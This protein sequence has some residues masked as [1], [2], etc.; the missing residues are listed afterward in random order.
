MYAARPKKKT[1]I[2]PPPKELFS[3]S[4]SEEDDAP[5]IIKPFQVTPASALQ[6]RSPIQLS[7]TI[8]SVTVNPGFYPVTNP[9]PV[10]KI[11]GGLP[12][13]RVVQI[14][15]WEREIADRKKKLK[16]HPMYQFA[17]LVAGNLHYQSLDPILEPI[18]EYPIADAYDDQN[19][20]GALGRKFVKNSQPDAERKASA[21]FQ[22]PL[23][24]GILQFSPAFSAALEGAY[25]D[26]LMW[27]NS[28]SGSKKR[29]R[30]S[31]AARGKPVFQYNPVFT[32][33]KSI[34]PPKKADLIT[35]Q[36][37]LR[38]QFARLVSRNMLSNANLVRDGYHLEVDYDRVMGDRDK[39][40]GSI[41]GL[42]TASKKL[43]YK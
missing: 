34:E 41:V 16:S 23:G 18:T 1:K 2:D 12:P 36:G 26:V 39:L 42:I 21:L 5:V 29:K 25:A 35:D 8:P 38:V 32:S 3:D 31:D 43:P 37:E 33:K 20:G 6:S 11:P 19:Q 9:S 27:L 7:E 4:G 30:D 17:S 14:A 13:D 10:Q 40:L 22:D 24:S 15:Q 28:D